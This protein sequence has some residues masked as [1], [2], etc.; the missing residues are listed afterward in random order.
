MPCFAM[1]RC[2]HPANRSTFQPVTTKLNND[3]LL[4]MTA[5]TPER[6]RWPRPA[7]L[8]LTACFCRYLAARASQAASE[9][10]RKKKKK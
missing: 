4:N 8:N 5:Q 9:S 6:L 2:L 1:L 3:L 10:K 7:L